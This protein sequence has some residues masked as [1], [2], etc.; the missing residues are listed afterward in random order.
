MEVAHQCRARIEHVWARNR[1][2]GMFDAASNLGGLLCLMKLGS[3]SKSQA[4]K[5]VGCDWCGGRGEGEQTFRKAG[6]ETRRVFGAVGKESAQ[7]VGFSGIIVQVWSV[8]TVR[9]GTSW[10]VRGRW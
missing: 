3:R 7:I 6:E 5:L 9:F 8:C 1:I 4:R 2:A 10:E